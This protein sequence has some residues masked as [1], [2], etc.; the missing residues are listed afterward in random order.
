MGSNFPRPLLEAGMGSPAR[1]GIQNWG[2]TWDSQATSAL[3]EHSASPA[4]CKMQN[5]KCKMQP[6][7]PTMEQPRAVG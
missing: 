3:C 4:K 1:G 2:L 5:V 7:T 6:V